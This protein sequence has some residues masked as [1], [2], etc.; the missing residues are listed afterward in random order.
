MIMSLHNDLT[1]ISITS[2]FVVLPMRGQVVHG[3]KNIHLLTIITRRWHRTQVQNELH[4]AQDVAPFLLLS[5]AIPP[6]YNLVDKVNVSIFSCDHVIL[7]AFDTR[8]KW[9]DAWASAHVHGPEFSYTTDVL[10]SACRTGLD[11]MHSW[12]RATYYISHYN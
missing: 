5:R 2:C 3:L 1:S 12:R 7:S 11:T 9:V 8:A 6:Q 4:V 10:H